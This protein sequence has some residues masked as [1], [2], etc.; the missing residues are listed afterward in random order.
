MFKIFQLHQ[1]LLTL[2]YNAETNTYL[3]CRE[4]CGTFCGVLCDIRRSQYCYYRTDD[5]NAENYCINNYRP[6]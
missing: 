5:E 6:V 4:F 1:H 3:Q 2:L